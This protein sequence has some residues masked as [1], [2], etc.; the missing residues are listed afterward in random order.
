M[1]A[2]FLLEK[3]AVNLPRCGVISTEYN[4]TKDDNTET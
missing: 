3:K 4:T 1:A 2:L